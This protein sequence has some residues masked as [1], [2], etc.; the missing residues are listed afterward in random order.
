MKVKFT[1]VPKNEAYNLEC[2]LCGVSV[3]EVP[4]VR[5]SLSEGWGIRPS[6]ELCHPC[7]R[8]FG[9]QVAGTGGVEVRE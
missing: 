2:A 4:L 6:V 8:G 5:G 1:Q 7:A 9:H 3:H